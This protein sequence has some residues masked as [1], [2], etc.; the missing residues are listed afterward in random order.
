M[1][2]SSLMRLRVEFAA[3]A[4]RPAAVSA[5]PPQTNRG[6]QLMRAA[7]RAAVG[8]PAA[9]P[10]DV[11]DMRTLLRPSDHELREQARKHLLVPLGGFQFGAV[12][13]HVGSGWAKYECWRRVLAQRCPPGGQHEAA[14]E[15]PGAVANEGAGA[16]SVGGDAAERSEFSTSSR[17]PGTVQQL[18]DALRDPAGRKRAP[19]GRDFETTSGDMAGELQHRKPKVASWKQPWWPGGLL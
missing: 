19:F 17:T 14:A 1:L 4:G 10:E 13:Q 18:A 15:V 16:E 11:S 6:L 8:G 7:L 12:L 9:S 3:P 5:G 2:L